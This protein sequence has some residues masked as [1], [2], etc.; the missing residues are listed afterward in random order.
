MKLLVYKQKTKWTC[1]PACLKIVLNYFGIKKDESELKKL[2]GTTKKDGTSQKN[3]LIFLKKE[4]IDFIA[5]KGANF[6][7]IKK[8]L[9]KGFIV[10]VSFWIPYYK[11][12]HYSI[13]KK[14]TSKRIYLH[15]TW[16][17]PNHSYRLNFF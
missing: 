6:R 12:S 1:G 17:G 5:K 13:V 4:G 2:L 8:Y 3:F 16:F 15:D 14:I 10:V 7:E 9:K 11:E